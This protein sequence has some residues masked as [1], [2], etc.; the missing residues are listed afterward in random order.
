MARI[1]P[2]DRLPVPFYSTKSKYSNGGNSGYIEERN[3]KY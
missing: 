1:N 2:Q 3:R